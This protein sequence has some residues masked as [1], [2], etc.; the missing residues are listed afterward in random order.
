VNVLQAG[1]ERLDELV[2][3]LRARGPILA[4]NYPA[5]GAVATAL[6]DAGAALVVR[7]HEMVIDL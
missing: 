5:G 3:A 2:A 1:G 7:Q 4:L 6:R